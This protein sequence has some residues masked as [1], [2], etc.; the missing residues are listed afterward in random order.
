MA[1]RG[2]EGIKMRLRNGTR[3]GPRTHGRRIGLGIQRGPCEQ[4]AQDPDRARN[5]FQ[6]GLCTGTFMVVG[7]GPA[8]RK[9]SSRRL[10]TAALEPPGWRPSSAELSRKAWKEADLKSH[11][12]ARYLFS[13]TQ[14]S[15]R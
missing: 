15:W 3:D 9:R 6:Q 2:N 14:L 10:T 13:G 5:Q 4:S 8:R 12:L 1:R 11:R 7:F